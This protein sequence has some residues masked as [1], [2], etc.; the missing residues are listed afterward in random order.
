[1]SAIYSDLENKTILVTGATRGIGRAIAL[2]LAHQ[3]SHVIFNFREGKEQAAQDLVNEIKSIG[4]KADALMF[5]LTNLEQMNH[6]LSEFS[7]TGNLIQGL[8]NNA[9]I[10]KD[11]L[12]LR[13]KENDVDSLINTN[14]KGPIMLTQSLSRQFLKAQNVSIVNMS[15][16]VGLMGNTAQ[17][18][19]SAS[20]SGLLGFT[21]SIAKELGGKNI[22]CNAV[23]PGFITTDMTDGLDEKIKEHYITGI[24][25]RRFGEAQEVASLVSFL[26][27]NSSSYI[28]GEV[29]KVDGGMYI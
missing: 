4:A 21:K 28:T 19:Y 29:I 2:E 13:V 25:M 14:L 26:L 6:A 17:A 16:I 10:S 7:K 24:P 20:K 22:R 3:K 8:V 5:D 15:S 1:M 23:C 27:S 11:T 12:L 18:I 9:G